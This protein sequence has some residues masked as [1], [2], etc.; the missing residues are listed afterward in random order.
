MAGRLGDRP[1]Q[2]GSLVTTVRPIDTE[3]AP[4]EELRGIHAVLSA[5]DLE[6]IPDDPPES[7]EV[8]KVRLRAPRPPARPLH[9][10][11]AEDAGEVVGTAYAARWPEDDPAN[12]F[13]WLGVLPSHRRRGVARS[14]LTVAASEMKSAG[15]TQVI[16]DCPADAPWEPALERMGLAHVFTERLSRLR[17]ED[18]DRELVRSWMSRAGE[19]ANDYRLH[20]F[21]GSIPEEHL[22]AWCSVNNVM[23]TAPKENLDIADQMMTPEKWRADEK[24]M[25]DRGERLVA[26]VAVHLPTGEFVGLTDVVLP[27]LRPELAYQ[28][29]TAVDPAHRNKGLGRWLKAAMMEHLIENRPQM[30]RIYTGNAGSNQA[31]LGINIEMGFKPV[32]WL[33]AWQG[34]LDSVLSSLSSR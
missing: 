20:F 22:D 14:M 8:R 10:W 1:P 24:S 2:L 17:I 33:N 15:C 16:F 31:M 34:S 13:I 11:V 27:E 23:N 4:V 32:L 6:Q 18:L 5:V 7:F 25:K 21:E 9:R 19:R 30:D 12:T 26:Y 29:D 28:R 3:T